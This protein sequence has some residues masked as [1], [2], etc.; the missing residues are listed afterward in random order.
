MTDISD[1]FKNALITGGSGMVGKHF[2]FGYK[3]TSSEMNITDIKSIKS[4]ICTISE[5]SCI[6]HL[7]ALNLRMCES[8]PSLAI[9][10]NIN[11]TTNML[12]FAKQ[13]SI[14]FIYISSGAVFSST[15]ETMEFDEY[16]IPCPNC[17]YGIT[18]YASEKI[19]LLYDKTILIRTGWL[20][21]GNQQNHYKFV[22]QT[23]NNLLMNTNVKASNNF[24]GSPTY[25]KD[26]V[27]QIK[28]LIINQKYGTHHVVNSGRATGLD[29]AKEIAKNLY[30]DY[31]L[32]D[33]VNSCLTPN[34]GPM[35][36]NSETLITMNKYNVLRCWQEALKEYIEYYL[37]NKNIEKH[38]I[39]LD[40]KKQYYKNRLKC[41]LCDVKDLYIFF[42][43]EK[44]PLA[45]NFVTK[46]EIQEKI[47][48]DI[49][50]CN[51]CKH[52]QLIQIIDPEYLYKNYLYVSSTSNTMIIH[53][54][55]SVD[56]FIHHLRLTKDDNI[57]EIGANDGVCVK[58]L[59]HNG[60]KNIIGVDPAT[61]IHVRH[62]LPIICDYYGSNIIK[63]FENKKMK[64]IYGFHCCAHIE[65]IQDVFKTTYELLEKN[66]VFIIEVGYFYEI[67]KNNSFDTIYHEHI[68]Y[69]TATA[70]QKFGLKHNLIL[71]KIIETNIQGGSIQFFFSKNM[72][73]DIDTSVRETLEKEIKIHNIETLDK[74][75]L[76]V[77]KCGRDINYFLNSLFLNGKKIAGYGAS[78][79]STTF[80]HQFRLSNK[81]FEYIIDE[82]I[83]K[84]NLFTPGLNIPIKSYENLNVQ[85]VDYV[86]ILSW[87]FVDDMLKK[88]EKYRQNGLRII[89]P[90]PEIKII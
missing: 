48:L 58:H 31:S 15:I 67:L 20:F 73:I 12:F 50:I 60:F 10:V 77:L 22:E 88:L 66:G 69:H 42:N 52:I 18:K 90:F 21:G 6:I 46:P 9:D 55:K 33:S 41:R 13:K 82:N 87:N 1:I 47:P 72:D 26:L 44:T 54:K 17:I 29:I 78:A 23:I 11:G 74:F 38:N 68:D 14:P 4:Y 43:L 75:K 62:T 64:L 40:I 56:Y 80:L 84:E 5:I 59:L 30:M 83:Y 3:P 85:M 24:Y 8:N 51:N 81:L 32:I 57:L 89:I 35:R 2:D 34:P 39:N 28:I 70:I 19:A 45:N 27:N 16:N 25:V 36:S 76:N 49:S 65:N 79:K 53:L 63:H 86:I 37:I 71:Y 61:N 7:A